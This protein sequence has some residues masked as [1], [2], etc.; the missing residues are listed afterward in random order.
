MRYVQRDESGKVVGH[1]ANWQEGYAEEALS[2]DHVDLVAFRA[3]RERLREENQRQSLT[4]RVPILEARVEALEALVK[5][6]SN[7]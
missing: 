6:L 3:E 1:F 2:D 4:K 5:Q 7:K